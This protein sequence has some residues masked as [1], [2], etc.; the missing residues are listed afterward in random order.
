LF[1]RATPAAPQ[2]TN[3]VPD[4]KQPNSGTYHDVLASYGPLIKKAGSSTLLL[5]NGNLTPEEADTLIKEG[6]IDFASF[7]RAWIN[8][9]DLQKRVEAGV[10]LATDLNFFGLYNFKDDTRIGYTD[11]PA[12]T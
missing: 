7:G 12:A 11:Y 5:L 6:K 2:S 10:P 4:P 3:A 1:S 8:N 9:P